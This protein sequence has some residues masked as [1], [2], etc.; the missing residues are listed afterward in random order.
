M[1]EGMSGYAAL[2][3]PTP[4]PIS[5]LSP[6]PRSH[7]PALQRAVLPES[8]FRAAEQRSNR[9]GLPA[10]LSEPAQRASSAPAACCEQRKAVV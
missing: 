7:M 8:P 1:A 3:R 5:R 2:T 10:Q 4:A 9:R 6:L